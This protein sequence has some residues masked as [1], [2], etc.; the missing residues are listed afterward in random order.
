MTL[1]C[2]E[3]G[4]KHL[5]VARAKRLQALVEAGEFEGLLRKL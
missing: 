4:D 3:K 5:A 2:I 1:L